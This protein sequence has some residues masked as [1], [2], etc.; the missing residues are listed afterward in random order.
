MIRRLQASRN[1]VFDLDNTLYPAECDLFAQIDQRMT[2]FVS[3]YLQMHPEKARKLQKKYYLEHGTT[4]NGL[5]ENHRIEPEEFLEF[6]HDIDH[7]V[8][9]H[10]PD[11][12]RAIEALPG[13]KM[14]FTNGSNGHA[15]SVLAALG[16][17]DIFD[18]IVDIEAT[19]FIPK[20]SQPAYDHLVKHFDLVP[21]QSVL[22]EDLS[23]NL[24][25]A[26]DMG[27]VTV[28]VYSNKDWSHEPE[29]ARPASSSATEQHVHFS[30]DN[31]TEFLVNLSGEPS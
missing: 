9:P 31:L 18:G 24:L 2:K 19:G 29:A 5:M 28:L 14:V 23:R 4:L 25:P 3:E 27:F 13:R 22:F 21:D 11:L 6:V 10:S 16:L 26:H 20:P 8:L 7:S 15:T 1:W 17:Q 30:T 12:R